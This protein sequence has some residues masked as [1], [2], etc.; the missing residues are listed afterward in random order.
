MFIFLFSFLIF[1]C[2]FLYFLSFIFINYLL[3]FLF[4]FFLVISFFLVILFLS[5]CQIIGIGIDYKKNQYRSIINI[6]NYRAVAIEYFSNRVFYR[7]FHRL[8]E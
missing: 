5:C 6:L 8:I 2:F 4:L 1:Y 7:T 3:L